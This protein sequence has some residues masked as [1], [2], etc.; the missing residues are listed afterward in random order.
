[1]ARAFVVKAVAD[2]W[3]ISGVFEELRSGR[4]RIG[5]SYRDDLDLRLIQKDLSRGTPLNKDQK[6]A[7]RCLGFLTRVSPD[8]YLIYPH[9]PERGQFCVVLATGEY[10]FS[11]KEEGLDKDFRSFRPCSLVTTE[12]VNVHDEIV[13]SQLRHRLGRPG[14][15]SEIYNTGPL[16][17][18]LEDLPNA[19][20]LQD[21]SNR[22]SLQRIHNKLRRKLPEVLHEEFS[23]ADLSRKLCR[24]LFERMGYV[25]EIREGP[26]EVGS[27]VVVTLGDPLLPDEV[28]IRIGIQVFS[29]E[30]NVEEWDLRE[31]LD[32]L[33]R[34]WEENSLKYGA[35][36]T[37]GRCGDEARA[38]LLRHNQNEKNRPV[39][40]IDG[41][42]LAD[43]FLRYFPPAT[44]RASYDRE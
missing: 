35:L 16:S 6:N 33:L 32:Q 20:R 24:D 22:A 40:L 31:K 25:H 1:M 13:S 23:R 11:D 3:P 34:G 18:F 27:D 2:G 10:D 29:Y 30:G 12:P 38:L 17:E 4:A 15:F 44:D 41:D 21:D 8:D 7:R 26:T 36:L 43:L 39:R 42:D 5:W 14:R 19:G 37:T 28:E 9:Q